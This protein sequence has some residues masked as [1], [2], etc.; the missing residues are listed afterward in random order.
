MKIIFLV[1]I[2][3]KAS[4]L[5]KLLKQI[6][7]YYPVFLAIKLLWF[8][9]VS[10]TRN[11]IENLKSEKALQCLDKEQFFVVLV[12]KLLKISINLSLFIFL[13]I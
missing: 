13:Q 3:S 9:V 4:F 8:L 6:H 2:C 7:K 5:V 11:L 12:Q 1:A 10:D